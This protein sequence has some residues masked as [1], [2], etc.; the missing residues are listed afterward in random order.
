MNGHGRAIRVSTVP[1]VMQDAASMRRI[2][3]LIMVVL[4]GELAGVQMAISV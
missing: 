2:C 4:Q 3:A 1:F